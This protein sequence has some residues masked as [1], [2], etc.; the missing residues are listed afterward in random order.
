M[1]M[2]VCVCMYMLVSGTRCKTVIHTLGFVHFC[3]EFVCCYCIVFLWNFCSVQGLHTM[4]T[5]CYVK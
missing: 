3:E 5:Y 2:C 1:Y 4:R